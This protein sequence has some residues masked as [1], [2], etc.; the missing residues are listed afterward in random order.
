MKKLVLFLSIISLSVGCTKSC[1]QEKKDTQQ[2]QIPEV[3]DLLMQEM[4]VG[5]GDEAKDGDTVKVH[6]RGTFMDGK[7]FDSSH[8]RSQPFEFKLGTK[9]VIE[10]WDIGVR[11]M[12]VGG[13]RI[14]VVPPHMAYGD[15]GA[16]GVIPPNTPLKFEVELLEV[17]AETKAKDTKK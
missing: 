16:G 15:K 7:E 4:A 8:S 6:Y 10:G 12:K 5:A 13:K 2:K 3:K 14:L 1:T 11:G 9:Q 17:V